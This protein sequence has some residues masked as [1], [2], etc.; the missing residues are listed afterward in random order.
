MKDLIETG[1]LKHKDDA[2]VWIYKEYAT[3]NDNLLCAAVVADDTIIV[4][5]IMSHWQEDVQ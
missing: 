2:H 1:T 3:R 5:T 4:K